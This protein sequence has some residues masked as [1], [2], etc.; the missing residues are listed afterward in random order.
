MPFVLNSAL[1]MKS[2]KVQG[3]KGHILLSD[4]S[5]VGEI[6]IFSDPGKNGL[7]SP[8]EGC[9][10]GHTQVKWELSGQ[11]SIDKCGDVETLS[12]NNK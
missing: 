1:G 12:I 11:R 2:I 8:K 9:V 4:R 5:I 3:V 7:V 10:I 6:W